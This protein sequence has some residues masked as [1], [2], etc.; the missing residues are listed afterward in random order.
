MNVTSGKGQTGHPELFAKYASV[1]KLAKCGT[2]N[3]FII[4][5]RYDL[6]LDSRAT[7]GYR[8]INMQLSF[9]ELHGTP[10][11]GYVFELQII[12]QS[13]LGIKSDEGHKR[14]ITCRNLRG[15]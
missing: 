14:Y 6:E 13:Y 9:E 7:A 11:D 4:K 5:N 15:D 12:L 3:V 8:D 2:L 10:Y 1:E